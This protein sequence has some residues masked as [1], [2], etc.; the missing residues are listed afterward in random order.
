MDQGKAFAQQQD[1]DFAKNLVTAGQ[2]FTRAQ[3]LLSSSSNPAAFVAVLYQ[4]MDVEFQKA[5]QRSIAPEEKISHIQKADNLAGT[6]LGTRNN[7][8]PLVTGHK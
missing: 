5:F 7:P 3:S 6:Q 1:S 4:Q 8:P 2:Y